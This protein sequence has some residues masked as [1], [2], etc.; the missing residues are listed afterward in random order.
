MHLTLP[1]HQG[2]GR[3]RAG[4]VDKK[5]ALGFAQGI[6]W[7]HSC[8]LEA[9]ALLLEE[10]V[11]KADE[12]YSDVPVNLLPLSISPRKRITFPVC[13]HGQAGVRIVRVVAEGRKTFE[14][15]SHSD[16]SVHALHIY[17]ILLHSFL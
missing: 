10:K 4:S 7:K 6:S 17:Q 9:C 15:G 2:E 13:L 12:V 5:F 16:F 14:I 3:E 8:N 1:S 11:P